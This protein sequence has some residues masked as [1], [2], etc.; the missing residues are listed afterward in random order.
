MCKG[1]AHEARWMQAPH[2]PFR[3][4]YRARRFGDIPNDNTSVGIRAKII[5]NTSFFTNFS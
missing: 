5:K 3:R 4:E 2:E 1:K